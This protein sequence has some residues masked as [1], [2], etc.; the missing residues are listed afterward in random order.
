MDFETIVYEKRGAAAV[1]TLNRPERLNAINAVMAQEL[2]QAWAEVMQ[3][4]EIVSAVLTGSGERSFCTGFDMMDAAAGGGELGAEEERGSRSSIRF[5][6]IQNGCW[7]PVIT[8]VNG[9]VTGG[10]LH[11]IADSDLIV[12]ADHATFF[13][14]HVRVGLVAGL[15]PVGLLRRIPMEAVLRMS[16]LGGAERMDADRAREIGLVGDVVPSDQLLPRALE[17][18]EKIAQ[19]SPAALVATKRAIWESL[20][21]GL[22]DGLEH[23][24]QI[25]AAH[26][27]HPDSRE[28]PRAFAERRAPKWQPLR[29]G[30]S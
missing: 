29:G 24:W 14:N 11:F 26:G 17:L 28:G 10:G 19:H 5:T 20:D 1:V 22:E 9:M 4:P 16:L 7:K 15:E 18:A 27:D 2:R 23:A 6:A 13:D 25:I 8:A 3:D 12:A 30:R 21:R